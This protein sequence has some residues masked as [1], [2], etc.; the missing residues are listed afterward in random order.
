MFEGKSFDCGYHAIDVGRSLVYNNIVKSLDMQWIESPSTRS[1]V[2]NGKK[3]KR[4]YDFSELKADFS[5]E[6]K[7]IYQSN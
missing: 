3:V 1:L 4:G 6:N 2:F 7:N 5:S